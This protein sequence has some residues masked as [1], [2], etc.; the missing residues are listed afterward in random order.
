MAESI[1]GSYIRARRVAAGLSL[2][3]VADQIDTSHVYL[4]EVERGARSLLPKKYWPALIKAV[5][6]ITEEELER[7][8]AQTKPVQL[9]LEDAPPQYQKLGL[10]LARRIERRDL[11]NTEMDEL[12]R[13]LKGDDE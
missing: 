8:A 11:N 3:S 1:F 10:A 12:L 4:G 5:P 2:R 9:S 7:K 6:G 13:L